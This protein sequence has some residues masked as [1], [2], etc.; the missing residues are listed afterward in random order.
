MAL[1]A[2]PVLPSVPPK[3][4]PKLS[5]WQKLRGGQMRKLLPRLRPHKGAL[6]IATVMLL[7]STLLGLAFPYVVGQIFD[8]AFLRASRVQLNSVALQLFGLL[9]IQALAN[10]LQSYLLS[11]TGERVIAKLRSD[12]FGHL[13]SLPPAFFADRRTGELTSRLGAD[14]QMLQGVL[15]MAVTSMV[16]SVLTLLGTVIILFTMQPFLTLVTLGVVPVVV[17]SGLWLGERLK[18]NSLG[19]MDQ[20]AEATA[21]AEEAFSQIRVVQ[22]FAREDFERARYRS[23]MDNAV[24]V[25]LRRAVTRGLFNSVN[26]FAVFSAS[27]LVLWLGGRMVLQGTLTP[28]TLVSFLLYAGSAAGAVGGIGQ[29]WGMYLEAIGAAGRVFEILNSRPNLRDPD[30]PKPLPV[31]VRGG[32]EFR[33]VWFRYEKPTELPMLNQGGGQ[34]AMAFLRML[35]AA[36]LESDPAAAAT[37]EWVLRG[38]SLRIEPGETVALVGPSGAGK[39]TLAAIIPRF[40]DVQ[41]GSVS[42]DGI[43]VR[44][45]RLAELRNAVGLVPQETLLFSGSIHENIGYGRPEAS[46]EEIVAAAKVAHAHEFVQ[47][48]PD[49]Y[50]TRVGE[51]GI[52]LSGGQRQRISI[53]RAILKDP[54]VLILDEATS[55]LDNESEALIEDALNH[56]LRGRSTLIIAH[57]LS[58]VRRADRLLVLDG[59]EIV[60]EGTHTELLARNG[61]YARLYAHQFREDDARPV[62]LLISN[63]TLPAD[64]DSA[65]T[66]VG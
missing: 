52:K 13:L 22:S 33:D 7:A 35:G 27:V 64:E 38:V 5:F 10:F 12:L 63:E 29:L 47:L 16:Q 1:P 32:V 66:V 54:T 15:T 49:G 59:G 28:G 44:E 20:V 51:R 61:L 25:A 31:P 18:K 6:A 36:P 17:G 53:A 58:T 48:L 39:T 2:S 40:W 8:G 57:R 46:A 34:V 42:V 56:L 3:A 30:H 4:P 55:S 41:Q 23:R 37:P 45:L 11:A 62:D 60:E 65:A 19:V 21:V 50:D 43:D 26:S 9:A 24:T 14:V